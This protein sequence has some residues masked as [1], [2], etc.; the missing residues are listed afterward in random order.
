MTPKEIILKLFDIGAIKF[1]QFKLK[2]GV[3]SPIYIDLRE[4]ISFPIL[5]NS[6][7]EC[8]WKKMESLKFDR[9]CGVPY[10]ALPMASCLSVKYDLPMVMRR[11][12]A[13]DHGTKKMVEGVFEKGQTCLIMEDL[14]T[15]GIS[16]LETVHSLE[17]VGLK[18]NDVV[19]FIDREQG[20]REALESKGYHLHT[21]T[22]LTEVMNLLKQEGRIS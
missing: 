7:A 3:I 19:A 6:T 10:T 15:S 2:S 9:L 20:G 14:V 16:V 22:T 5:L 13:K 18:V 21:V 1:G 17:E 8:M 11:K 4:T 12:E